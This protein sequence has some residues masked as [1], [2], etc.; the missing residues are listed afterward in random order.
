[1]AT[2]KGETVK[3]TKPTKPT[4][5]IETA[6]GSRIKINAVYEDAKDIHVRN[7]ILYNNGDNYLYLDEAL[8]E[9]V[10][11]DTLMDL[12]SKGVLICNPKNNSYSYASSFGKSSRDGSTIVMIFD[13]DSL[14]SY[15]SKEYISGSGEI[16]DP[17]PGEHG[18]RN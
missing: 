18:N 3:P 7:Y 12:C 9:K 16:V 17:G 6:K 15:Y 2:K 10:D 13:R 11:C 1:M 8:T 5:P 14:I 4:E